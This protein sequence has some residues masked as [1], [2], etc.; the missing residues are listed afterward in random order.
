MTDQAPFHESHVRLADGRRLGY[1]ELGAPEGMPLL[2]FPGL[3]GCS[4]LA[5]PADVAITRRCGVRMIVVERP[6]FGISD[7]QPGRRLLDYPRDIAQ[8]ADALELERFAVAGVSG[9]GPSLLACAHALPERVTVV[10]LIG[11]G[12]PPDAPEALEGMAS[13]RKRFTGLFRHAPWLGAA[14]MS[15]MGLHRDPERFYQGLLRGLSE[16]DLAR[17]RVPQVW[18]HRVRNVRDAMQQGTRG[19]AHELHIFL[20][21]WGFSLRDIDVPV[22]LWHGEDDRSTPI[23]MGRH[24]AEE[25]PRCTARFLPGEGHFLCY[26]HFEEILRTLTATATATATAAGAGAGP[27]RPA[28]RPA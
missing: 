16:D 5:H 11:C 28:S 23:S 20:T 27:D 3:P 24:M 12:G 4:R 17:M 8:L 1:A 18:E 15:L 9:G 6:G 14:I 10:G 22:E 25:L 26:D 2:W 7:F 21:P 13:Q 19:F